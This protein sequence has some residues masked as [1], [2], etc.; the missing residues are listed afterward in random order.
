MQ[1]LKRFF[2]P[3]EENGYA[4][5][6][7]EKKAVGVMFFLVVI[8]F[9][10]A[11][12]QTLLIISSDF[13]VSTILPGVLVDLTNENRTA[14]SLGTL[15]RSDLLDQ[16]AQLKAEDMAKEGYFAHD[17]PAGLSPWHWFREV[18][19]DYTYAGENLAVRFAD[20][21]DV[22]DAWMNSP[23]HRANI[24]G[25][26]YTEIGIGT[27]E[28]MYKG[29]PTV[30]VVQLFGTPRVGEAVAAIEPQTPAPVTETDDAVLSATD[31][32]PQ[33]AEVAYE[34]TP[35]VQDD[36]TTYSSFVET[37]AP[38]V[39][40]Q[41]V[42]PTPQP[43]SPFSEIMK[44]LARLAV[45]PHLFLSIVYF[46]LALFVSVALTL[47]VVIEARRQHPVQ[48]AYGVGLLSVMALMLYIH[49]AIT[50]GAVIA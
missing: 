4:P 34:T 10:I 11:N 22:V 42:A 49:L 8:T 28:G 19:Y 50:S 6:S 7:L 47:S 30:F 9:L 45:G 26:E 32:V 14:D 12:G 33:P 40:Q 2:I 41:T 21:G 16:A 25:S 37:K 31:E 38:E 43:H 46:V 20:S 35:Q 3:S 24:L 36:G 5:S 48:V 15:T 39:Q 27:A 44:M 29:S 18:G 13:F 1:W 23:G 17:S